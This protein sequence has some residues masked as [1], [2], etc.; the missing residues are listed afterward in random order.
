MGI[1]L[2]SDEVKRFG[3][4]RLFNLTQDRV[5]FIWLSL[6]FCSIGENGADF[7]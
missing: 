6:R 3:L 4:C 2:L 7:F 5:D 1:F